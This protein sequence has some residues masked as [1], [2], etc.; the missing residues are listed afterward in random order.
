[1]ASGTFSKTFATGYTLKVDWASEADVATNTSNVTVIT[2]LVMR[3]Y[4]DLSVGARTVTVTINGV[5]QTFRAGSI[6]SSGNE[7][8][9]LGTVSQAVEHD[10]DGTKTI[11]IKV[12]YPIAAT[13]A[14]T[15]YS[16]VTASD[17][18]CVLDNIPRYATVTQS[19]SYKYEYYVQM[20]WKSTAIMD[21]GWYSIDNGATWHDVYFTPPDTSSGYLIMAL[22]PD[23]TYQVITKLR[24]ADNGLISQTEALAVT[25]YAYPYASETPNFTIG[26]DANITLYNPLGR[27]VTVNLLVGGSVVGTVTTNGTSA[28]FSGIDN[29]LYAAIPNSKY[30]TYSVSVSYSGQTQTVV[31]GRFY[32]NESVCAPSISGVSYADANA[33]VVAITGNYYHIVRNLSTVTFSATGLTARNSASILAVNVEVNGDEYPMTINGTSA[34]V[35]GVTIDSG[36]DVEAV[37]TVIDSRGVTGTASVTVDMYDWTNPTAIITLNRQ[38]N[39]YTATD[40]K[41]DTKYANIGSNAVV[42][43]YA[44]T[45][46]GDLSPSVSGTLTDNVTSTINLDNEYAWSVAVTVTDSFGGTTT[47]TSVISRGMPII[48]FDRLKSSVGVN[49]FPKNAKSLEVNGENVAAA[50]DDGYAAAAIIPY[51]ECDST[52][53]STVFTATV[54]GIT[55][56]KNGVCMLLKNGVVT[57]ASGCTLNINGLG[58]KPMYSSN[59]AATRVTTV[60]NVAYTMLFVYDEDRV[61]GGCWVMY[62]GYDSNTNTLAYQVRDYNATHIAKSKVYRYMFLFTDKD[63]L[64]VPTANVS[65]NTTTTKTL[66][67]DS[68]NP[69]GEIYYYATT[70]AIEAGAAVSASNLFQKTYNCNMRY[71]FNVSTTALTVNKPVYI[72]CAPQSDGQVKLDGNDCV[73]QTLPTAS[74]GKLYIFLGYAYSQYQI[75]LEMIHPIFYYSGMSSRLLRWNGEVIM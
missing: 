66:T 65:N 39:Y 30:G 4:Y 52:S 53:T 51:G 10:A 18:A 41:V 2:S 27:T 70:T 54:N 64:V 5:A 42:I 24:R 58:A 67:T 22:S 37:F 21:H 6:N 59:A 38:S 28:V 26:S 55:E 60:F 16:S 36:A 35:S 62:Y 15:Y 74:D 68:F 8:R 69:F 50:N 45:K 72:R 13:L 47:Y 9:V 44:A 46:D 17:D 63:N 75:E 61:D 25:T 23:T 31:G 1:M 33:A 49:C 34:S 43:T 11:E 29:A 14:G 19:L 40:I 7:T 20:A 71:G 32:V 56:L 12:K 57:S 3:R 48:Y 73:V